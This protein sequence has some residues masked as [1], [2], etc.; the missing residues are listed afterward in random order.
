MRLVGGK[1]FLKIKYGVTTLQKRALFHN[2]CPP[3]TVYTRAAI[4]FRVST[5]DFH[6]LLTIGQH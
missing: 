3:N 4:G 5:N 1:N 2:R 6:S